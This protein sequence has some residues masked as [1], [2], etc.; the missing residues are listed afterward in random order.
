MR[1][2]FVVI[3]SDGTEELDREEE[4][5]QKETNYLYVCACLPV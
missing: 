5:R 4:G 3:K 2:D 1:R